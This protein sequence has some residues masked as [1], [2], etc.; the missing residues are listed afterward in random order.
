MQY[1][2]INQLNHTIMKLQLTPSYGARHE[3]IARVA[4]GR[5]RKRVRLG[6]QRGEEEGNRWP[7]S[8]FLA[9]PVSHDYY[10]QRSPPSRVSHI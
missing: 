9:I 8:Y 1:H 6:G 3:R 4:A 10:T 7:A 2:N 5:A